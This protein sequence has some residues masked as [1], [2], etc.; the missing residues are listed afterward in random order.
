LAGGA[1]FALWPRPNRV[2]EENC[3]RIREGMSREEVEA[4][5]GPPG[6]YTTGPVLGNAYIGAVEDPYRF[7][8][9]AFAREGVWCGDMGFI[10]VRYDGSGRTKSPAVFSRGWRQAQT[11][12]GNL[13][14]RAKRQWRR[15]FPEP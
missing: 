15:C 7:F 6:D 5:L 11:P 14:W 12:L 3:D 13:L 10:V 8:S 4:I 2:T 9:R 1:A